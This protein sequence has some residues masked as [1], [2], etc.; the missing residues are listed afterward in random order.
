[1]KIDEIVI[2]LQEQASEKYKNNVIKL[3]IPAE[4]TIGVATTDL[5][6]IARKLPKETEFLLELWDTGYH[7]CKILSVLALRPKD[8][9]EEMV[10][11]L[12]TEIVSWDLCDLFCKNILIKKD[13]DQYIQRWVSEESLYYKRAA[14]TLIASTSV[15]ATLSE[16]EI[17]K[18]L[19]LIQ[20]QSN[21]ERILVKKSVSWAL[22][23][24]GKTNETAKEL[25]ILTAEEL[26]ASEN[27]AQQW[28]GKDALKELVTLVKVS[29]RQRLISDK[30]KMG[31]VAK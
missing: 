20:V 15:H 16:E 1:M 8:V 19:Q 2:H 21:D 10:E 18:Y 3:G 11:Q 29:G 23:E 4:N 31:R 24:L 13:F 7:E 17:Q 5:R 26:L 12:M 14:F 28:I 6:K 25:S 30:S 9:T 27:K 22:R